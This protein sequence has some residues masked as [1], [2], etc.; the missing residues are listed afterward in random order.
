MTYLGWNWIEEKS[1]AAELKQVYVRG[2]GIDEL[3]ESYRYYAFGAVSVF[4]PSGLSLQ[5]SG[6]DNRFLFTDRE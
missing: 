4:N 3:L 5:V 2:V 1:G 6:F